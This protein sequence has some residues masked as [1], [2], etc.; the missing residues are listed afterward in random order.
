VVGSVVD[1]LL[2]RF[3]TSESVPEIFASEFSSCPKSSQILTS[4]P[5]QILR[6]RAP[7]IG[8]QIVMLVSRHVTW[9][10]FAKLFLLAPKLQAHMR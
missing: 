2:F 9:K 7:K 5:F 8:V 1:H 4:L 3:L 6:V 10:S